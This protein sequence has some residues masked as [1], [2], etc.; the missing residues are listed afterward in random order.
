MNTRA[1]AVGVTMENVVKKYGQTTALRDFGLVVE[2][3]E[4]VVLLGPSGCGK[5]TAL[6]CLAGLESV[7]GGRI[8]VGDRDI[9]H[10]PVQK[11]EMAMVFQSYS[12]FPHLNALDNVAFGLRN[13]KVGKSAARTQA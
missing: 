9:T 2:S 3:G 4:M 5:T 12:L 8:L 13:K 6:R 10:V 7:N 1:D 11:R